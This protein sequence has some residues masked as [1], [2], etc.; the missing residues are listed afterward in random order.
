MGIFTKE[1]GE[2]TILETFIERLPK[3]VFE[4]EVEVV[5]DVL[6]YA[7][8]VKEGRIINPFNNEQILVQVLLK[9][10]DT[11]ITKT[12]NL[13]D[14][15]NQV[16][17]VLK[18]IYIDGKYD[19]DSLSIILEI[20]NMD[21]IY[22]RNLYDI[23]LYR[24]FNNPIEYLTI[25]N[26]ILE[27]EYASTNFEKINKFLI[28]VRSTFTSNESFYFYTLS[29]L[30]KITYG[31]DVDKLIKDEKIRIDKKEGIYELDEKT[32]DLISEKT[33]G[34]EG[35]LSELERLVKEADTLSDNLR[36]RLES[37]KTD[38][39]K[40]NL[41]SLKEYHTSITEDLKKLKEFI[42]KSKEE[43]NAFT[44]AKQQEVI[45]ALIKEQNSGIKAMDNERDRIITSLKK[46]E[47]TLSTIALTKASEISKLGEEQLGELDNF[48]KN[49]PHL[50]Q[51]IKDV[52][53]IVPDKETIELI[54]ELSKTQDLKTVVSQNAQASSGLVIPTPNII[55]PNEPVD[56]TINRYFDK[57][58][59]YSSRIEELK[60]KMEKN[61]EERGIIYHSETLTILEYLLHGNA[62]Y[63][64][65]PSGGGKSMAVSLIADLLGL[66]M[67]NIGYINEEYQVTGAEPFLNNFTPSMLHKFFKY[68]GLAFADELDNGNARATVILNPFLRK[69]TT[70]Y[71]FSNRE[72]VK[73]HPNFR[74]IAAGN[75]DGRGSSRNH[76]TREGIEESV[77]QR[78]KP[79]VYIGY[80]PTIEMH[81]LKK[82]PE[83]YNF[84]IA[85]REAQKAY[86]E[87]E[88][89]ITLMDAVTTSDVSD[90]K[91][92][93][94]DN[95]LTIKEIIQGD[96][97][98]A[99]SKKY[100]EVL[101]KQLNEHY[102]G[103]KDSKELEIYNTYLECSNEYIL[104]RGLR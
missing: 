34:A 2:K 80:D 89:E 73:R 36:K 68:G 54:R 69:T 103:V 31:T 16:R 78:L 22:E 97:I 4:S 57:N 71:T 37:Y 42:D 56:P 48:V 74:I 45:D 41:D 40:I 101:S 24:L 66:K 100:L 46:L 13:S 47:E 96:F 92:F 18:E 35:F 5:E 29:F 39:I 38:L 23:N 85:F 52:A 63:L 93:L 64:Y 49:T 30:N 60:E 62:P 6:N 15:L 25:M 72:T 94:D 44:L 19:E 17:N 95:S 43:I 91:E 75:T 88:G 83:W 27:S 14:F 21:G 51:I 8:D 59:S 3:S 77:F 50:K 32:L 53:Q 82:Y 55:I 28:D 79:K 12:E 20:F 1:K 67:A 61:K 76:S 11:H 98:Q 81:I 86:G 26:T 65:G 33:L 102:K 90:I 99:K 70:E 104:K 9:Y 58:R 87:N 10:I 7:K 84:I